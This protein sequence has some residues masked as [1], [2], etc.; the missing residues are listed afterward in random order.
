M[1]QFNWPSDRQG[2]LWT[3]IVQAKL[4][5]QLQVL[6]LYG[7][8]TAE[9]EKE[10]AKV[11]FNDLSNREAVV[12]RQ[13]FPLLFDDE[14]FSRRD[15]AAINAGLDYGYAI[16]LSMFNRTIVER[17]Y[18][19]QLGIHHHSNENQYNLASDLMEPFRPVID[20][21]VAAQSFNELTPD[22]KYGLIDALNLVIR[23]AGQEM[24]LRN[25]I[26]K[27]VG[28]CMAFLNGKKKRDFKIEMGFTDEV[29]NHA[30]A[31]HV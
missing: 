31:S 8:S 5:N 7:H 1:G 18:L 16:L 14:D 28:Q 12:A 11:E 30:L 26:E 13:Y 15:G 24:L 2:E 17:G 22:V 19:P 9:L 29:P 20:Y 27:F 10:L 21:W 6:K 23:Y 3:K 4:K 25:A